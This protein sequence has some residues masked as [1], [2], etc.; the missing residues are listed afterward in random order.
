M[1]PKPDDE[2]A[3][4]PPGL[5]AHLDEFLTTLRVEASLARSTLAA[6]RGDLERCLRW[7]ARRGVRQ[8]EELDATTIV[9][10]LGFRRDEGMAQ[11]TLAR[12]L[13]S[14]RLF[15]RFLVREGELERDP[16]A[17]L[18]GPSL[19]RL[20]PETMSVPEVESMLEAAG[21]EG[22]GASWR[23]QR[24]RALLE[25][26]YACGARVSEAVGLKVGDLEPELRVVRLHGK[27]D[28]MRLVPLG[29]RARQALD[30]WLND[31]RRRLLASLPGSARPAEVFLSARG[32][33]LDRT[34]AWRRVRALA[35]AAG[36]RRKVSPHGLR[37]S[38]AT[39]L[40]EGGADLRSVQEMLGHAS[41]RTTEIYTHL[42]AGHVRAVHRLHH[43]RA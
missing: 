36:I 13:T 30:G 3:A 23:E 1:A 26:L 19:L 29:D 15:L 4:L 31:G 14:L 40:I 25:L 35:Q 42:D 43:P 11:A 17:L 21:G 38:F 24:D 8:I 22:P 12:Q 2:P 18:P 27:G 10:Y 20:L 32:R 7:A 34:N 33:P 5:A 6:Y 28:K 41:I 9:D 39:H 16:S 37:H